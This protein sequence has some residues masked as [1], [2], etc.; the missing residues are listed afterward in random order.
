MN[1]RRNNEFFAMSRRPRT[2]K[3]PT[4]SV[5]R[6][7]WRVAGGDGNPQRTDLGERSATCVARE[8]EKDVPPMAVGCLAVG[9]RREKMEL[10]VQCR[11]DPAFVV[12]RVAEQL[13]DRGVVGEPPVERKR[14]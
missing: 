3:L 4:T 13:R 8:A 9:E 6:W 14:H 11:A 10:P 12:V 2:K 1:H 5:G 7:S